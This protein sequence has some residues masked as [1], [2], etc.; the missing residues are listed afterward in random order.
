MAEVRSTFALPHDAVIRLM[1]ADT[2]AMDAVHI[3]RRDLVNT[4]TPVH[5]N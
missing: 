2:A 3:L 1:V 4:F 5:E